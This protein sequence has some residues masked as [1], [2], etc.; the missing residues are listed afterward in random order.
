MASV[1]AVDAGVLSVRA[2]YP[3]RRLEVGMIGSEGM[4]GV[5]AILDDDWPAN[6]TIVQG[7]GTAWRISTDELK[8]AMLSSAALRSCLLHFAHVFL[9]QASQTAL[10]NGYAKLEE[11]LARWILM[12]QDRFGGHLGVTHDVLALCLG[13]RRPG[14]TLAMHF[15]EGRGLIKSTRTH[16]A[17]VDRPGLH[18]HPNASYGVP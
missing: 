5:A 4:T 14:V 7:A 15:L 13:V 1:Y 2:T 12:S 10:A 3:R 17:L 11:R 9:A 6:E 18:Q 16:I 8:R